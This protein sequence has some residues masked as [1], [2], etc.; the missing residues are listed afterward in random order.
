[1]NPSTLDHIKSL[2]TVAGAVGSFIVFSIGVSSYLRNEKWKKAEF[3]A[4]EMK[5]FFAAPRIQRA[6]FLID[7]GRRRVQLLEDR[8]TEEGR[9]VVTR[10]MQT[11]ALRPH[12]LL[13]RTGSDPE[14]FSSDGEIRGGFT[15]AEAA[16]R[17][18]YDAFLDGLERF[19]SYVKTGL[20]ELSSLRPYLGYWIDDISSATENS[21]DAAWCAAL[22]TY[23][24]FY[25]FDGV[26][27][28]FEAFGRD[29]G[30][31]SATYLSF[32]SLMKDQ[33]LAGQLAATVKSSYSET[34][35]T[36]S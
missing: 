33:R 20:V 22:L 30:P 27:W 11:M 19:S 9:V 10:Q 7:W 8:P 36:T 12:V 35:T 15:E 2:V 4:K 31:N 28:L 21:D 25:R 29:I 34:S 18:C 13:D 32:L 23:V 17:D 26:L 14:I 24:R 3:L 6:M 1:M 5:E 16:I